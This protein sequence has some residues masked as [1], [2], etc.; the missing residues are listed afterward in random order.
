MAARL[1]A[2]NPWQA[3]DEAMAW[4]LQREAA[5]PRPSA[6]SDAA[7]AARLQEEEVR[8]ALP[9][10]AQELGPEQ[11]ARAHVAAEKQR[12]AECEGGR[13]WRENE[14]AV[15]HTDAEVAQMLRELHCGCTAGVVGGSGKRAGKPRK[16]KCVGAAVDSCPGA[17]NAPTRAANGANAEL[18]RFLCSWRTHVRNSRIP[19]ASGGTVSI[20]TSLLT[21]LGTHHP[22][23]VISRLALCP[24]VVDSIASMQALKGAGNFS[25]HFGAFTLALRFGWPISADWV[26]DKED[27]LRGAHGAPLR[28]DVLAGRPP[29]VHYRY[30]ILSR[31]HMP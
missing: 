16:K 12:R 5:A 1:A 24:S 23:G 29:N 10:S 31:T 11:L 6:E 25:S 17:K 27:Q 26:R 3:S 15:R 9:L 4:R 21:T 14:W 8:R 18:L 28:L 22:R 13:E 20:C 30:A 7:M 19:S 2:E